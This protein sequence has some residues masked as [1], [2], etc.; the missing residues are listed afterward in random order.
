MDGLSGAASVTAILHISVKV[1]SLCFEYSV[2]VKN[3]KDDIERVKRKVDDITHV[4]EKMEQLLNRQDK[5]HL[6]TTHGL[7][8]SIEQCHQEL[9]GLEAKLEANLKPSNARKAMGRFGMRAFKWPF[10]SKRVDEIILALKGYEQ[11]FTLA[12]QV[13][14]T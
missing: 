4:L 12:L 10:T 9:K 7:F 6:S 11:T 8:D 3:A 5:T 2:D 13:D 1:A 14:Q